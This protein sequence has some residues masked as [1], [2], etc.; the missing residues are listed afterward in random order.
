[1]T[2][3]ERL[4]ATSARLS[5]L[6]TSTW[7]ALLGLFSPSSLI[8]RSHDTFDG[9]M[10]VL[11]A[12]ILLVTALGLADVVWHDIRGRL[13]WPSFPTGRR[14]LVC[15]MMYSFLG[16]T[17]LLKTFVAASAIGAVP[18]ASM[19]VLFA[20]CM[21]SICGVTAVALALEER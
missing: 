18:G 12:A 20:L 1:M 13:I 21:A 6:V 11:N 14:H 7:G 2:T 8:A 10:D 16:A 4:Y 5:A 19:L 9:T 3:S 15:V 17:W